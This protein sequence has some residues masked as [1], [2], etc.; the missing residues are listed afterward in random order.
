MYKKGA[1]VMI[2]NTGNVGFPLYFRVFNGDISDAKL[3][4]DRYE[5]YVNEQYVGD[6][7]LYAEKENAKDI[8]DFLHHQGFRHVQME[9]NGDHIVVISPTHEEAERMEN[10]LRVY[11]QN[12]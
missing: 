2:Y 1:D 10:A 3:N 7:T 6:H 8:R 4:E 9:V 5:L 11:V 12:R